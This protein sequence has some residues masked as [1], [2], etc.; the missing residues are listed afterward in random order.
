MDVIVREWIVKSLLSYINFE[1]QMVIMATHEIQNIID[2]VILI[3]DGEIISKED[4]E[5]LRESSGKSMVDWLMG[6]HS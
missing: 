2:E 3:N 5:D 1:E 6:H 4:V